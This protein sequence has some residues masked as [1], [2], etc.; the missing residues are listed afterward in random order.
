MSFTVRNAE[1]L[2]SLNKHTSTSLKSQEIDRDP[3]MTTALHDKPGVIEL[4][5]TCLH[6]RM[7]A[8]FKCRGAGTTEG[9]FLAIEFLS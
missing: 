2:H 9:C 5:W 6:P 1:T 4:N 7:S 3:P 8:Q